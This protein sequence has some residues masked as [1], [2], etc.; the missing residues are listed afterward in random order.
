M[1]QPS[2]QLGGVDDEREPGL[3]KD[4]SWMR[5]LEMLTAEANTIREKDKVLIKGL[6]QSFYGKK[7]DVGIGFERAYG[8]ILSGDHFELIKLPDGNY[9]FVFA[10]ISGHG[11]PAYTTL[12]RLRSAI[13]ISIGEAKRIHDRAGTVNTDFLVKDIS[14]KFTDIMEEAN[15]HDFATVLFTFIYNDG[16]KY[17]LRFYNRSMLFPIIMRKYQKR[18]VGMYDLNNY[19]KGWI[20]RKGYLM[21]GD[22]RI[23]TG[24]QYLTTPPCEFTL[25][26]GDSILYFSDG[27][28]EA[29]NKELHTDDFGVERIKRVLMDNVNLMPQFIVQ[30]LFASVYKYLGSPMH[31]KDDMTAVLIDFPPVR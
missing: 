13:T 27:I 3:E 1:S 22:V 10:D 7:L 23:L 12:V 19:E 26:E 18:V 6:F 30:E 24:E 21:S 14:A 25:Y 8:S 20:P 29:Y 11:L 16:D 9:L 5:Q 28:V 15:S 31:Q 17:H 4:R 2:F